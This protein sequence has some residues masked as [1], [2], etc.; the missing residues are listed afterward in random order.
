MDLRFYLAAAA[1]AMCVLLFPEPGQ[2]LPLEEAGQAFVQ[3]N[4]SLVV[5]LIPEQPNDPPAR[6]LRAKALL[7]LG[8]YVEA[9]SQLHKLERKLPHMGD[10]VFFL[11]GEA[12]MGAGEHRKAARAFRKAGRHPDSRFVD[13]SRQRRADA[14]HL[15]RRYWASA[16]IYR[17]L[18]DNYPEHPDRARIRLSLAL[19]LEGNKKRAESAETLQAL[20]LEQPTSEAADKAREHLDRLV[21]KGTRLPPPELGQL[22]DRV[23][24]LS[25]AKYFERAL[26]ELQ[27]LREKYGRARGILAQIELE[28]ARVL[29]RADQAPK[30]LP[31]L[32]GLVK[33]T[34]EPSRRLR[35]LLADCLADV[36]QAEEGGS[37]LLKGALSRAKG[38]KGGERVQRSRAGDVDRAALVLARHG[39]YKRALELVQALIA[40]RST[41]ELRMRRDWLFFRAGKYDQAAAAMG[42]LAKRRR[43]HRPFALYWAARSHAAAGRP[44]KAEALYQ[45]VL[46]NHL[47]TYYG[48]LARSRLQE[49]GKLELD[50]GTCDAASQPTSAPAGDPVESGLTALTQKHGKLL[51]ALVRAQTLWKLGMVREARQELRLAAIDYAWVLARGRPEHPIVRELAERYWQ[52]GPPLR[53]RWNARARRLY[54]QRDEI[55]QPLSEVLRHAGLSYFSRRFRPLGRM[56]VG[57]RYARAFPGPVQEAAQRH[58]LDP[59]LIWAIMRT[60]SAYHPDAISRVGATG[61]MQIMPRTARRV[62]E[63][64]KLG[65]VLHTRLFEPEMNLPMAGWYIRAV[66]DKFHQQIPLMAAAYNGGP[67]NVARWLKRRG[68]GTPMDAFIEEIAFRESRRYA[69]KIVRLLALYERVHCNKDDRVLS[70]KLL[71]DH[72][73]YPFF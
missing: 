34:K 62:A 10:W 15:A 64:L 17:R 39:R 51:P 22:L 2:A 30:A 1:G 8:R 49:M 48:I 65:K 73:P 9:R 53:R 37:L 54:R 57:T 55:R 58:K 20:W 7:E 31:L 47:R 60:E 42:Q 45:Q 50:P 38:K 24:I 71:T 25:R 67:H 18:L 59:N 21:S 35:W 56:P 19:S 29:F 40:L 52:G 41:G 72:K 26:K 4:F 23:R 66:M 32:Q 68:E 16:S 27:A 43:G 12:L 28:M 6:L 36:G 33:R 61:L 44:Q 13:R 63:A 69:K 70:N 14:L 5:E 46:E 11:R 3:S